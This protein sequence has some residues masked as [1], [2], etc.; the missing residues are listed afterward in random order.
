MIDDNR[1]LY[2]FDDTICWGQWKFTPKPK[3]T[4]ISLDSEKLVLMNVQGFYT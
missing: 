4:L 1:Q 2:K 3:T